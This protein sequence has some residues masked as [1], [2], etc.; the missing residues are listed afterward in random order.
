MVLATV[1]TSIAAAVMMPPGARKSSG[2]VSSAGDAK[3][4]QRQLAFYHPGTYST[5]PN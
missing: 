5:L 3:S 1:K 4:P 2:M